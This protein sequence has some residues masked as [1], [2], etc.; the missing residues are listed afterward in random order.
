MKKANG[1][2]WSYGRLETNQWGNEQASFKLDALK[3]LVAEAEAQNKQWVNLSV[4]ERED[5]PVK[6]QRAARE[7][8]VTYEQDDFD[9]QIPF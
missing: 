9:Q 2:W 5:K 8:Q 3:E 4:F 7:N 1:K 6:Q